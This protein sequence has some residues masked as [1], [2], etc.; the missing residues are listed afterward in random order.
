M[1][2]DHRVFGSWKPPP[3]LS[4]TAGPLLSCTSTPPE[5]SCSYA[6]HGPLRPMSTMVRKES[7][8]A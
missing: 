2:R 4:K 3:L 1:S 8:L 7:Y 6:C 5:A